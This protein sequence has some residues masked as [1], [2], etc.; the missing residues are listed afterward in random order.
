MRN[1]QY[2]T[3]NWIP[4]KLGSVPHPA[5]AEIMIKSLSSSIIKDS[6]ARVLG[7][8]CNTKQ[9]VDYLID[10]IIKDLEQA[11]HAAHQRFRAD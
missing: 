6:N 7:G 3:L 10:E 8:T 2:I 9:E 11:R 1:Y 4:E 5:M